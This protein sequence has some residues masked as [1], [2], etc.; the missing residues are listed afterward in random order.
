MKGAEV[1]VGRAAADADLRKGL[2]PMIRRDP[3][4]WA[5]QSDDFRRGYDGRYKAAVEDAFVQGYSTT[6]RRLRGG[7]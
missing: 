3:R 6:M 2:D 5:A 1:E 4:A 7:G